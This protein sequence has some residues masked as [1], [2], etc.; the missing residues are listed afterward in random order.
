MATPEDDQR[1]SSL[2]P[3]HTRTRVEANLRV[4]G[5]IRTPLVEATGTPIQSAYSD[6]AEGQVI[7]DAPFAAALDD[8]EGFE[9]VWLL[10]LQSTRSE[11]AKGEV[12]CQ[13]EIEQVPRERPDE[14]TRDG[15][16]WWRRDAGRCSPW[17]DGACPSTGRRITDD[18]VVEAG[19]LRDLSD[20]GGNIAFWFA[21]RASS[22]AGVMPWQVA[23]NAVAAQACVASGKRLCQP[24]EWQ[25]ACAGPDRGLRIW[26]HL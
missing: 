21:S 8:L 16:M 4:I 9:R 5:R 3:G 14:R 24:E 19:Q 25:L 15:R 17:R 26:Q 18:D 6:G 1:S 7:V 2:Q 22:V 20:A 11:R 10:Y 12:R 23:S 13:Q